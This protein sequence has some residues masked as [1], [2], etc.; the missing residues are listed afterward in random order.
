MRSVGSLVKKGLTRAAMRLQ[1]WVF[2]WVWAGLVLVFQGEGR[3]AG[4]ARDVP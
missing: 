1:P 4:G 2:G 3:L